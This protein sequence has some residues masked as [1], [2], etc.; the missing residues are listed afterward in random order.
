MHKI[1]KH[2]LLKTIIDNLP[3]QGAT[4]K[5]AFVVSEAHGILQ[6]SVEMEQ[7]IGFGWAFN[8]L[9]KKKSVIKA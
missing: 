4:H 6:P 5:A 2:F 7:K 8:Q 9:G 3:W 1:P